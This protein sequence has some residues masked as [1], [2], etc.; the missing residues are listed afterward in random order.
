MNRSLRYSN[1]E[2][3][4]AVQ[5]ILPY[6]E[7]HPIIALTGS[8]GAGKTT[9]AKEVLQTL[10]VQD[11]ITS[12]TYSYVNSYRTESHTIYHFDLYR[13]G[14]L[15]EFIDLGFDE[16]LH[17]PHAIVLIEWPEVIAPLLD[18]RTLHVN[19]SYR[20]DDR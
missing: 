9:L 6:L 19:L 18:R 15:D 11:V 8:L 5:M 3:A 12:P 16:Y 17:M 4:K 10:G 13:L 14:S 7:Q 20:D 1:L 2:I